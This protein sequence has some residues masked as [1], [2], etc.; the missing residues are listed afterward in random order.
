M[1]R[2]FCQSG[3]CSH[4][5]ECVLLLRCMQHAVVLHNMSCCR[6]T[7][8]KANDKG[9]SKDTISTQAECNIL[10][11]FDI[12]CMY[13]LRCVQTLHAY[14]HLYV[15]IY[16]HIWQILN[17]H[18][19]C[20]TCIY[21]HSHAIRVSSFFAKSTGVLPVNCP[22]VILAFLFAPRAISAATTPAQDKQ[23]KFIFYTK[24]RE[25]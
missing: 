10:H 23:T 8:L 4:K 3:L 21:R 24:P 15:R 22:P 9:H 2:T 1:F 16:G 11:A 7:H 20:L 17:I 12:Q 18:L 25:S 13:I 6:I 14:T 5:L 19:L